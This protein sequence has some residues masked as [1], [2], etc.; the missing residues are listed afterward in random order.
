MADVGEGQGL[1]DVGD[2][3]CGHA[4]R[5]AVHIFGLCCKCE[6]R[7]TAHDALPRICLKARLGVLDHWN[8]ARIFVSLSVRVGISV[9][10]VRMREVCARMCTQI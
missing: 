1:A 7:I 9:V 5:C 4:T 3:V 6:Q 8:Q 2:S 10:L